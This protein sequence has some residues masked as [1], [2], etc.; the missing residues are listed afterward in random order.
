MLQNA[1]NALNALI[2]VIMVQHPLLCDNKMP[3]L[4]KFIS[5]TKMAGLIGHYWFVGLISKRSSIVTLL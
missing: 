4:S 2:R 1:K 3:F 5:I